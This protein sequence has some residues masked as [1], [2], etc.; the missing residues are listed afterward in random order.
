MKSYGYYRM[1]KTYFVYDRA[2]KTGGYTPQPLKEGHKHY[3]ETNVELI[4][5]KHIKRINEEK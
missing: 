3:L 1:N 2:N 4:M 5:I